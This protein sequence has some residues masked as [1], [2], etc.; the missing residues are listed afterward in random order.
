MNW[1]KIL[2]FYFIENKWLRNK[3]DTTLVFIVSS[4]FVFDL[5]QVFVHRNIN[6][7]HLEQNR[8]F[9]L[10]ISKWFYWCQS[11]DV[12]DNFEKIQ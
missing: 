11:D 6:C 10:E 5:E 12:I 4:A 2:W 1:T 8:K 7:Y 9:T 3:K